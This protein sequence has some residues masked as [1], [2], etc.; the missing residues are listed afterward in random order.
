MALEDLTQT[1]IPLA[2]GAVGIPA[3]L[4]RIYRWIDVRTREQI[5]ALEERLAKCEAEIET[6]RAKRIAEVDAERTSRFVAQELAASN[7]ALVVQLTEENRLL[8]AR[9]GGL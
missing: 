2:A 8:R 5:E 6:L 1:V 9:G 4:W 7:K 3:L